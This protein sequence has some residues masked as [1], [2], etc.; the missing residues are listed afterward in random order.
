VTWTQVET[1]NESRDHR[2]VFGSVGVDTFVMTADERSVRNLHLPLLGRARRGDGS[3]F[4]ELV[5]P[6]RRELLV[7]RGSATAT[8]SA[9]LG[10]RPP[11]RPRL[12]GERRRRD[13][14]SDD[15]RLSMPP[16]PIQCNGPEAIVDFLQE[17]RLW[18]PGLTLVPTRANNQPAFVYYLP[19]PTDDVRRVNGVMVLTVVDDQISTLTRFGGRDVI[20]RFGV[21]CI[22]D[23]G[24]LA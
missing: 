20:A 2:R 17:R 5:A 23:G 10:S 18:G 16:E 8:R 11:R 7:H 22:L 14:L 6:H 15:S 1:P 13:L 9:V 12:P 21:P 24:P 3:A 4:D 19:D